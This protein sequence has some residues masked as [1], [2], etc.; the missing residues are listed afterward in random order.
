MALAFFILF[1]TFG[2]YSNDLLQVHIDILMNFIGR[3]GMK[4]GLPRKELLI[5]LVTNKEK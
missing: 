1:V 3:A 4:F 5:E 2:S